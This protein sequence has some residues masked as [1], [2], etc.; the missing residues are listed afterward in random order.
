MRHINAIVNAGLWMTCVTFR[1][2]LLKY[3]EIFLPKKKNGYILISTKTSVRFI[4][5]WISFYK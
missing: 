4:F 2:C 1:S 3:D 5:S